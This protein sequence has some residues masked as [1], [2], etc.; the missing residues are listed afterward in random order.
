[1]LPKQVPVV[2]ITIKETEE[3]RIRREEAVELMQTDNIK[4]TRR[5]DDCHNKRDYI[6][7]ENQTIFVF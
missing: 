6:I 3:E 5:S 4:R 2:I 7:G 1:V